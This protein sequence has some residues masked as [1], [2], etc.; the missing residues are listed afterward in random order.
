MGLDINIFDSG[1]T[2]KITLTWRGTQFGEH[3]FENLIG[4]D[5]TKDLAPSRPFQPA[6]PQPNDGLLMYRYIPAVGEPSK[7]DA[8]YAVFDPYIK[9]QVNGETI[10]VAT[11]VNKG[12]WTDSIGS[13]KIATSARLSFMA[14]DWKTLPTIHHTAKGLVDV[15]VST[16]LEATVEDVPFVGDVSGARRIE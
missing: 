16:I 7:S 9:P 2:K 4:E 1:S 14:G 5:H 13:K 15:P 11:K 8:E 10:D 3:I 6:K 12:K